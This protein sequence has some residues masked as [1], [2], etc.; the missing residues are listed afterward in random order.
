MDSKVFEIPS[1]VAKM[2]VTLKNL[3]EGIF[4]VEIYSPNLNHR[5][6]HWVHVFLHPRLLP[7]IPSSLRE[8]DEQRAHTERVL[9]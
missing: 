6:S 8:R 9:A 7:S 4:Y 2:S 3:I 5:P 1:Q